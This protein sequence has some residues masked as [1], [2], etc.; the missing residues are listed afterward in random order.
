MPWLEKNPASSLLST[1][2]LC[3]TGLRDF[4]SFDRSYLFTLSVASSLS[5]SVQLADETSEE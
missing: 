4:K 5:H 1:P 2:G 3:L